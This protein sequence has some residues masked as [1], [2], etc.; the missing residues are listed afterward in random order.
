MLHR[1]WFT[2][3]NFSS[4]NITA[5]TALSGLKKHRETLAYQMVKLQTQYWQLL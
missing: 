5:I 3:S 2:A 1:K 4:G